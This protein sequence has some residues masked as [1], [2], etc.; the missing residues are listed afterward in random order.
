MT[1]SPTSSLS[2]GARRALR[3][4]VQAL[5]GVC[6][7]LPA[8]LGSSG[9]AG[10]L[11]WAAG[12]VAV[13]GGLSRLMAVPAVEALLPPWLRTAAEVNGDR[14]LRKLPDPA[15]AP[16]A[17]PAEDPAPAGTAAGFGFTGAGPAAPG[18]ESSG[19]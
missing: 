7:L 1:R 12:A 4:V 5:V 14:A 19:A 16:D 11:P 2:D 6:V 18:G 9:P 13:A 15:P 10:A 17:A 8:V 3:T